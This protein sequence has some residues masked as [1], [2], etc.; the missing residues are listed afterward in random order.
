MRFVICYDMTG[1][2]H[3][4]RSIYKRSIYKCSIYKCSIVKRSIVKRSIEPRPE[5]AGY[6][7]F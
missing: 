4:Q 3:E 5:G 2:P 1:L 6:V 7:I